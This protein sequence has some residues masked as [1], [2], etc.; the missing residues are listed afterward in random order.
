GR[1][2]ADQNITPREVIRDFIE[3]LDIMYQDPGL[4]IAALMDSDSFEF[5]R[6]EA[7]S[8][9]ADKAFAEFTI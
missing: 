3:L 1:I 5:A 9:D 6:S 4:T 2:G 7:V 8:D